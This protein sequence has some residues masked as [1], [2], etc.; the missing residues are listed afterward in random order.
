MQKFNIPNTDLVASHIG[1]GCMNLGGQWH[2]QPYSAEERSR[3]IAAIEI[4]YEC[5]INFFDHADIYVFGKSEQI[6][7]EIWQIHPNLRDD[8]ILQSK[9]GIRFPDD[10]EKGLPGRYDFSFE[11]IVTSVENILDRLKVDNLDI[12][13]LHRPDPLM[14]PEEVA[15][16]FFALRSSGKVCH[17]GVSNFTAG[18]IALLQ[19]YIDQPLIVNQVELNLL[20]SHLINEGVVFNQ[21]NA[22]ARFTDGTLDYCRLHKMFIQ[23][24]S[25]VAQGAILRD[26]SEVNEPHLK[27]TTALVQQLAEAKQTS[28]EAIVLSWLLRHPANIQPIIGT[29][30]P[31]R[32]RASAMADASLLTREEW[33]SLFV[34][35]RGGKMP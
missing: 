17:F 24:W 5:G 1:F 4:A 29:T 20:H 16:A 19:S 25:P 18:Q 34:A 3:A 15:K 10:P 14:E 8:I 21:N 27:A 9:C 30:K 22:N 31:E 11:H 33:Y 12:L 26:S 35:A 28:R 7:S 13:L 6:F 32:I 23:A 2:R